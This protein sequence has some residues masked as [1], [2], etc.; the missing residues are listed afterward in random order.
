[1]R[2]NASRELSEVETRVGAADQPD[3]VAVGEATE[4]AHTLGNIPG[5]WAT[6]FVSMTATPP[7]GLRPLALVVLAWLGQPGAAAGELAPPPAQQTS[8]SMEEMAPSHKLS[9][10]VL[11]TVTRSLPKY[12]P[13]PPKPPPV[14]RAPPDDDVLVLPDMRVTTAGPPKDPFSVLSHKGRAELARKQNPGLGLGPLSRLNEDVAVEVLTEERESA[15]RRTLKDEVE[16]LAKLDPAGFAEAIKLLRDATAQPNRDW[17]TSVGSNRNP[18]AV[19]IR[20]RPYPD[21]KRR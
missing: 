4:P 21:K 13:A 9:A 15:K 5:G 16:P 8:S 7:A 14:M 11:E 1:M 18:N 12:A 2:K 19:T 20:P 10:K 3:S 17:A 6:Q